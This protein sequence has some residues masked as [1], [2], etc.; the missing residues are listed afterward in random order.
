MKKFYL[1]LITV[2][3]FSCSSNDDDTSTDPIIGI[4][5]AEDDGVCNPPSTISFFIDNTFE[6]TGTDY[7]MDGICIKVEKVFE[8]TS[9]RNVGGGNYILTVREMDKEEEV[10]PF[11]T[12]I[13]KTA[14]YIINDEKEAFKYTRI[15]PNQ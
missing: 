8:Y 5:Y 7:A 3:L 13:P 12:V 15:N 4:W 11:T 6:S 14:L 9:W 1:I 2:M 10:I